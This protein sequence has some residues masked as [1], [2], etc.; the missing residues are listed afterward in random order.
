M[1]PLKLTNP[2]RQLLNA[3]YNFPDLNTNMYAAQFWNYKSVLMAK[4][5]TLSNIQYQMFGHKKSVL[6]ICNPNSNFHTSSLKKHQPKSVIN[7]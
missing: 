2:I 5:P 3:R 6:I 4:K 1:L 7:I